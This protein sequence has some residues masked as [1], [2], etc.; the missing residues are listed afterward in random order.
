MTDSARTGRP[1]QGGNL[2][3]SDILTYGVGKS[4]VILLFIAFGLF[5]ALPNLYP[6]VPVVQI[7]G[8]KA[9]QDVS[10]ET[11]SEI[12]SSLNQAGINVSDVELEDGK[13]VLVFENTEEQL[14]ARDLIAK[15]M[16][17]TVL[18]GLN[19]MPTTPDWLAKL[20]G[21]PM[22]LGLDLQG[23]V[24]FLLEVD[25][26]SAIEARVNAYK[27][28]AREAFRQDRLY[29]KSQTAG[30]DDDSELWSIEFKFAKEDAF[31]SA[32]E[33]AK[34]NQ[35]NLSIAGEQ[36]EDG[37]YSLSMT[38][39]QS[40]VKKIGD[41]ALK[42]NL[43]TL[44]NRVNE[45]GVA[46]PLVQRQGANRIV[47]E[48]PGVQD[49]TE[50]GRIIGKTA[51]LEFRL[52]NMDASP[53]SRVD[54]DSERF[55]F[56]GQEN[57]TT[58]LYRKVIATGDQVLD[59]H[60]GIDE[61]GMPQVSIVLDSSGGKR[62]MN[63]TQKNVGNDMAVLFIEQKSEVVTQPDGTTKRINQKD[64]KVI[65]QATIRDVLG[66][67]FVITGLDSRAEASE[68][69][70]LLRAGALAAPM[71]LVEE[72]TIGPSLGKENVTSGVQSALIGLA[73]VMVFMLIFYK[74]FGL[75]ANISLLLNIVMLIAC[76]SMFSATLTLPGI[77]GI[78]LTVGMAVDANVLIF[79]RIKEELANGASA[80]ES[81][82]AGYDR[83]F[84]TIFDANVTTFV[85]ALILFLIGSGP[86]K[87]FAVTLSIG[88]LTS[89]FT[90]VAVS[91]FLVTLIYGRRPVEK[92]LI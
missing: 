91:R 35:Q 31:N 2:L 11:M 1:G 79:A 71:Y 9:G 84:V 5:Y 12:E 58:V 60:S 17:K 62:M 50:A 72:S 22:A 44:R 19:L 16:G 21:K 30:Y 51:N 67:R 77:A 80:V 81:V 61:Q 64:Q 87:G 45:L 89:M 73:A 57:R 25:L 90:A 55:D 88:I 15:T 24:H 27:E 36:L 18:A 56:R 26:N 42:Q 92:I 70:L 85:V 40:E 43:T 65:N 33:W 4:I 20:G 48:L 83:A 63:A 10:A 74:V 38:L 66:N 75:V 52:V 47:V 86:I 59:A 23:G 82:K 32:F 13:G 49:T 29:Y 41:D 76:L 7:S 28:E 69:A 46:E 8:V 34:T 54:M 6:D 78:V 3:S 39:S 37:L 53:L 68:L 14:K